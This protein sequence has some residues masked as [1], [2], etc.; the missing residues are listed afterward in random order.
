MSTGTET[1]QPTRSGDPRQLRVRLAVSGMTC[2][3]CAARIERRLNRLPGVT[4]T[5]NYATEQ[6]EV[7][8]PPDQ[9]SVD[10]LVETVTAAGY[11]ATPV[12]ADTEG[13][14]NPVEP[15]DTATAVRRRLL[16]SAVLGLPVLAL[17]MVPALQFDYWQ[18]LLLALALPV[19]GWGGWPF[20]HAAW[21]G[22]RHRTATMDTL[23]SLGVLAATGWSLWALTLG[24][25]GD[26]RLRMTMNPLAG[27]HHGADLYLEVATT[28]VVSVLAGRY[29]ELRARARAG[30]ALRSLLRL[31]AKQATVLRPDGSEQPVPADQLTVGTL[32]VVRP[33]E[34]VA[35]DGTVVTG[36]SAVDASILTGEPV[37]VE[38]GPGSD[39]AGGC[40]NTTGRLV[41][42]ATRVGTA[43]TLGRIQ[44]LV[45]QAQQGKAPVQRLADRIAAVFVPAVVGLALLTLAGWLAA[46]AEP[47]RAFGA[48]VAVLIIACPCALGLATPTALLVGTGRGA[49]LGLLIR[50]VR[51]L[52]STRRID[53]VLLDKTGT[54][55]SGR[56]RLH[57]VHPAPGTAAEEALRLVGAVEA[58]SEHPIARAL[59]TAAQER[60]GPLPAVTAF[61]A[62][63]GLGVAGTV[64]GQAVRV[65]RPS[66]WRLGPELGLALAGAEQSGRTTVVAGWGPAEQPAATGTEP[67]AL[68]L[69]ELSDEPHP[70]SAD[71]VRELRA[72]GLRVGLVTGDTPAAARRV[73]A[74]V[75][76]DEA[77]GDTLV[78]AALPADKV[79]LVR[80]EQRAGRVVA[81]V[82]DGVN[83]AAAL[84]QA[85]L[86]IAMGTGTD[87]AMEAGDLTV[88]GGDP[89]GVADA[90]RLARRVLGTIRAN[91]FWAFAYNVAAIP[92]AAAG[93]L[94]PVLAGA[95]MAASSVFVVANSL[96][97][98]RFRPRGSTQPG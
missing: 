89:R 58:G 54:L 67:A 30:S 20:H 96:R 72:L 77:H 75:G 36:E 23:V 97:L 4:A 29:F 70:T 84:A 95:A 92:L 43:T 93:L 21:A 5:V 90:I 35:T 27:N 47:V 68:V 66:G 26:P 24:G 98:R 31:G 28:L 42:Q 91:L 33:G 88:V 19:A 3:A 38:V 50:G 94:S 60:L 39:V 25:A 80:A 69:F 71:A 12:T 73:A 13:S 32:F 56:M 78:A 76:I 65:G 64:T 18:W 2:G 16:V 51:V 48:A 34:L 14:D 6:A 7:H 44:R 46:G 86:G 1:A 59:T 81:M 61:T 49:Q 17:S 83:D 8:Y 37:P 9:V 11:Q 55:T 40:L 87:V 53:T 52:E 45:E 74:Q 85:D 41:V 10:Q 82:G 57:A 79:E 22:L 63:P 15:A 62:S